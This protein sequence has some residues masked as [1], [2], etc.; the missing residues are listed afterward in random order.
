[1]RDYP[2]M[3]FGPP[4]GFAGDPKLLHL[5]PPID[6]AEELLKWIN[7]RLGTYV[8]RPA[9]LANCEHM[10]RLLCSAYRGFVGGVQRVHAADGHHL[11][12]HVQ[13]ARGRAECQHAAR[14]CTTFACQHRR[15]GEGH[16]AVV[17]VHGQLQGRACSRVERIWD[18]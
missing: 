7:Q 8:R 5:L 13:H 16:C 10:A 3:L 14:C 11:R 2:T 12:A 4:K 1:V 15:Y 18:G 17:R 9:R 6:S